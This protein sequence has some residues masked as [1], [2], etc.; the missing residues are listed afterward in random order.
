M[1]VAADG[2]ASSH[3]SLSISATG[4][5]GYVRSGPTSRS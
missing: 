4:F 5:F 1:E 3:A 2:P